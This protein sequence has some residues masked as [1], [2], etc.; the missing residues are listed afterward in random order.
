MDTLCATR[1]ADDDRR[2]YMHKTI[3]PPLS[4]VEWMLL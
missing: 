2:E 3:I 1:E 4:Q